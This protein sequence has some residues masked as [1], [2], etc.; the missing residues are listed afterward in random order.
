VYVLDS[1]GAEY[2]DPDADPTTVT[3]YI[4][5]DGARW[6]GPPAFADLDGGG[7]IEM[8]AAGAD[9]ILYAWKSTGA[10][11][12][13]GDFNPGTQGV[14]Y[15]AGRPLA[16]PPMLVDLQD[17]GVYEV[18]VVEN[19]GD[20]LNV[21]FVEASGG[22][23]YPID[24]EFGPLWPVRVRGQYCAPLALAGTSPA[25][26]AA[27]RGV[28]LAWVDTLSARAS[29]KYVPAFHPGGVVLSSEPVARTWTASIPIPA[30][31]PARGFRLSAPAVGDIDADG[32][33]EV[34]VTTS[35]G[36]L[37]IFENDAGETG[38]VD[39]EVISL[40]AAH[41]SAPALGDV[42]LDGTMEIAVWDAEFM[43]L[44]ESNGRLVTE[45]PRR[46]VSPA[47]GEQPPDTIRRALEGPLV[48]DVDGD[49]RVDVVFPLEN[50]TVHAFRFD[51][52]PAVGFP[53]VG[54]SGVG[55]AP[56]IAALGA[57]GELALVVAGT[58]AS[59]HRVDTV[60]DTLAMRDRTTVS[61]QSLPGSS[62]AD[63]RFWSS[64]LGGLTRQGR[65]T[66]SAP[67]QTATAL[68]DEGSFMLYPNPV[69]GGAVNVRV[70]LNSRAS[71]RVEVYNLE[72]EETFARTYAANGNDLVGTPFDES[73]DVA[74]MVSGLYF[75]RVSVE[76]SGGSSKM[77][78]P[79]AIR[80]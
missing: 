27:K 46:I 65:V 33:D 68:L 21:W 29:V 17:D 80:R 58:L 79:F 49:A 10:E 48:G 62:T 26:S 12:T 22:V 18:A 59:I 71:V 45:W 5:A 4:V 8:V 11:L 73:I 36:R 23:E 55:A 37:F 31:I 77:I 42:D 38:V 28:V 44:L 63:R 51:G 24:G 15:D 32:E 34:V 67:L 50:G 57:S 35:D 40:R 41:P 56:T 9:G 74:A 3:P 47:A 72:G 53:R 78:K 6:V 2:F 14:L 43:Y 20:S 7:D 76:G 25:H 75:V 19:D 52:A 66:G 61:I 30:G 39:P 64:A 70:T 60:V 13:D 16:A 54:P 69:V 1:A